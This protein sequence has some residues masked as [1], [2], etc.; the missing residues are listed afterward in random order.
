MVQPC[1]LHCLHFYGGYC[2]VMA[3]CLEAEA[4]ISEWGLTLRRCDKAQNQYALQRQTSRW[5]YQSPRSRIH[6]GPCPTASLVNRSIT[7][8]PVQ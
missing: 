5:K 4:L 3:Y 1:Q 7:E 8:I 2:Q 6:D